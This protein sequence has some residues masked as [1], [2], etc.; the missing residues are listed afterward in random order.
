[1]TQ[2]ESSTEAWELSASQFPAHGSARERLGFLLRY[3]ILAPSTHNTQ[4]W[5]FTTGSDR[6]LVYRDRSRWLQVAD[7]SQRELHLSVGCALENLLIAARAFGYTDGCRLCGA[8]RTARAG[9]TGPAKRG[10]AGCGDAAPHYPQ[11]ISAAGRS[12]GRS[13]A[14]RNRVWRPHGDALSFG[15]PAGQTAP[16]TDGWRSRCEAV[17]RT[18]L[19]RGTR[20]LDWRG[21]LRQLV[22]VSEAGSA[23]D[24]L[25]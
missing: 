17:C 5:R 1:M 10:P 14:T 24:D 9:G 25:S 13:Q 21:K 15:R 6:L 2:K 4:P 3:A 18:R 22:A 23:R 7:P 16:R 11:A 12:G 20:P 19:P 8:G